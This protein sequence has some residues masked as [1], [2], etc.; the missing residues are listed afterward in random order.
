MNCREIGH[1]TSVAIIGEG[2]SGV[3]S[4]L[5]LIERDP[6]LNITIFHNVPFE[7]T[8]SFGPAGLFRID[9]F[10]NRFFTI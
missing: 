1:R 9:T 3:S 5:A 7:Q 2:S 6:S 10:Q 8:V 4:A